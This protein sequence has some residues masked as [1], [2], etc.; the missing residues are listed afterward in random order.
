MTNILTILQNVLIM[1]KSGQ[2][3]ELGRWTYL[4]LALL[5]AVEGPIATLLGAAAA[6]AGL[7]R[8]TV[9]FMA[10]AAGNLTADTLW[11]TL[12]YLGKT[13]WL[14]RVGKRFQIT[15]KTLEHIEDQMHR[16]ATRLLFLAKLSMSLMIPSLIAAGLVKVPWRRWFPG[17][18][19]GEMIWTGSLVLIGFYSTVAIKQVREGLE[20]FIL[21][22][23]LAFVAFIFWQAH[24]FLKRS[25]SIDLPQDDQPE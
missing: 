25:T 9:V 18:F 23:T 6:A 7:M 21:A 8:P 2:L 11:Y 12:G 22:G 5:V 10:A 19:G 17:V 15:Q 16:H 14:F 1:L 4:L 24:R 3:P 20:G 13:E